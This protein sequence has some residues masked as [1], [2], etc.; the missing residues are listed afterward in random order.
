MSAATQAEALA[1]FRAEYGAH[2]AAE[3]RGAGGVAE[4][5]AL[6]YLADGP[7]A[8]QWAIRSRTYD[9]FERRI[10]RPMI[11]AAASPVRLLDLG[12]GNGWLCYRATLLGCV[13]TAM[14]VRDDGVDGLGAAAGYDPHL[15]RP[16]GRVAAS[17]EAIPAAD[18]SFDV[19]VFNAALHYALD[20]SAALAEAARV[21]RGGGRIVIL[22]SPFY[23]RDRDGRAMVEEK[24]RHAAARFGGRAEALIALP[25]IEYLTPRGLAAASAPLGL[26]WRRHRVRYPIAYEMRPLVALLKRRRAPS[27]FDLWECTVP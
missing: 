2:R 18:G 3:G 8:P 25:F 17:F 14:D 20:L 6:P 15:P 22:D 10:L 4:L 7:T 23:R 26:S 27:R 21:V 11:R 16:F 24:R 1:R 12:A 5:L 13:A 9:A 19:A